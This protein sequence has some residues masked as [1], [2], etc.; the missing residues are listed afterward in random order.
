VLALARALLGLIGPLRHGC[1][2]FP[3]ST[4]AF[5]ALSHTNGWRSASLRARRS[6]P[7]RSDRRFYRRAGAVVKRMRPALDLRRRL[8]LRF[9]WCGNFGNRLAIRSAERT[10]G[11]RR[12]AWQSRHSRHSCRFIAPPNRPLL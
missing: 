2:P 3:R 4:F 8:G 5:R 11:W 12:W 7:S 6:G 9:S 10:A 1:V